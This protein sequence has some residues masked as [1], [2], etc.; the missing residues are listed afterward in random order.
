MLNSNQT[1]TLTQYNHKQSIWNKNSN[2]YLWKYKLLKL[3]LVYKTLDVCLLFECRETSYTDVDKKVTKT[4]HCA[5]QPT[6]KKV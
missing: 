5:I 4:F 6:S 2:T 1:G 3:L